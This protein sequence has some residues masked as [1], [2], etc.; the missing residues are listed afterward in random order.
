MEQAI[1]DVLRGMKHGDKPV[2]Y[3]ELARRFG[4]GHHAIAGFARNLIDSGRAE[5]SMIR[6]HG[7]M[8]AHGL[9][10]Q[11]QAAGD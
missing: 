5:A 10:P 3:G 7:A 1:L 2:S 6:V 4:I 8:T 9:L 11:P